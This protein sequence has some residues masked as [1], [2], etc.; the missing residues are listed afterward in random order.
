MLMISRLVVEPIL[1][2]VIE[3]EKAKIGMAGEEKM[4]LLSG[5]ADQSS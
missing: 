4:Q 3:A 2:L 5:L 1:N